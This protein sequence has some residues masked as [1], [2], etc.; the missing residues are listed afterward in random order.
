MTSTFSRRL[1]APEIILASHNAGKLREMAEL[2]AP[3]NIA[4]KG[5]DSEG[6]PEPVE[7]GTD[8][9]AN[10]IIKARAAAIATG[11]PALAD[12]SGF[13]VAGLDNAPGIHS[14]RWA[15]RPDGTR[16]FAAAMQRVHDELN[17]K[18]SDNRTAR[19]ISSLSIVWPDGHDETTIG[20]IEGAITWPPRGKNGFGYDPIFI[21]HGHDET[22]GEM[23]AD[24]KNRM[25]HRTRAFA[26]LKTRCL[27]P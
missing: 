18:G 26:E 20:I 23:Q 6:L 5:A 9:A 25:S 21:P 2:L 3:Y 12:D 22:F 10:A 4:V 19:F 7:D 17:A 15:E 11:I 13:E 27:A 16:D 1:T 8:Y 14:A 24:A